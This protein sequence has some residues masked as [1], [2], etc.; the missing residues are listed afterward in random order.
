METTSISD[1][2]STAKKGFEPSQEQ[3]DIMVKHF[4]MDFTI[5]DPHYNSTHFCLS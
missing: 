1:A 3:A 5:V 2:E 4:N